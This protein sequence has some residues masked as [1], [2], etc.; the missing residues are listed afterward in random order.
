MKAGLA[1]YLVGTEAFLDV[2]GSP[3]GDLLFSSVIEEECTG[4]GMKA[5]LAAGYDADGTLIGEPSALH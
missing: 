2:C 3:R 1:A 5:V 4:N